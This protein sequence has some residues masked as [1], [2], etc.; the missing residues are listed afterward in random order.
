MLDVLNWICRLEFSSTLE[1]FAR[2]VLLS[3]SGQVRK[4]G[5]TKAE[6]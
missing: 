1:P 4:E 3:L 2:A 6:C 5:P